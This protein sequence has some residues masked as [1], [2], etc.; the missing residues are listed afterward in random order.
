MWYTG[1]SM[2]YFSPELWETIARLVVAVLLGG[3]IGWQ[4]G[5][6][7]H[8]AGA[9]TYALVS[10]GSAAFT[11]LSLHGLGAT[12]YDP[13][14]IAAQVLVG[15]GFIG[16]GIILHKGV[17][18]MGL[19]T[20]AAVWVAAAI[21]MAVGSG[22]YVLGCVLAAITFFV[23]LI[24]DDRFSNGKSGSVSGKRNGSA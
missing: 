3:V 15:I 9:R 17:N 12:S 22:E 18:V 7:R 16:G 20:A 1:K 6:T 2:M 4:R 13:T 5:V 23:L 21:G 8:S 11:V 19:T 24:D 14:R 10:L